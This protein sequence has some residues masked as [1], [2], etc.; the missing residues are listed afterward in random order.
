MAV[1]ELTEQVRKYKI[2]LET[3]LGKPI[4]ARSVVFKWLVPHAAD[5]ISRHQGGHDGKV[6]YQR[7]MGK[8]PRP[9]EVG[10]GEQVWAKTP[11]YLNKRKRSLQE[12][13]I[14][15]TYLGF[16]HK[17]GRRTADA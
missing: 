7:L 6:P 8:L 2:A 14:P 16:N 4:M 5:T 9:I 3:N 13:A 12:R 15:G 17:K 11:T 1:Q 10:F